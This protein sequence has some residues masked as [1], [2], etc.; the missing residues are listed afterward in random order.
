MTV[1]FS[2]SSYEYS[3]H[4]SKGFNP[5][6]GRAYPRFNYQVEYFEGVLYETTRDVRTSEIEEMVLVGEITVKLKGESENE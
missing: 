5:I 4:A 3:I 2:G 6:M 1:T